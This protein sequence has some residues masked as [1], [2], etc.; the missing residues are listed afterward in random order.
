VDSARMAGPRLGRLR[1]GALRWKPRWCSRA[2]AAAGGPVFT[3]GAWCSR[4]GSDADPP[5][6][7]F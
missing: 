2:S 4:F 3:G 7:F 6:K 5:T 1:A